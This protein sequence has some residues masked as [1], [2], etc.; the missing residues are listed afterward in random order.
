MSRLVYYLILKP[1]SYLP[2]RVLYLFSGI[3]YTALFYIFRYRRKLVFA[4]LKNSFPNKNKQEIDQLAKAFYK[5]LSD[6]IIESIKLFSI[7]KQDLLKRCKFMNPEILKPY[8]NKGQNVIFIGAHYNNWEIMTMAVNLYIPYRVGGIYTP[9]SN[10]FFENKMKESR[11]KYGLQ[12]IPKREVKSYFKNNQAELVAPIFASDQAPG[13]KNPPYVTKFLNQRTAVAFGAE[14][15]AREYNY[16]VIY[17]KIN[18]KARGYYEVVL[19]LIE[20]NP[21]HT[22]H[23]AITNKHV[24][25]LENQINENPAFWLWSHNRWKTS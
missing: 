8:L 3:F 24:Q 15:Y 7:T 17:G 6:L 11:G 20:E 1:I 16:P 13:T 22:S 2:L 25:M 10:K 9:M 4:N 21:K 12:L 14:K 19:Q 23:G 18:K 5:H